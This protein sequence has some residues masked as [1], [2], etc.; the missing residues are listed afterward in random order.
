MAH[1][2]LM[3]RLCP[4]RNLLSMLW[5]KS[6][7]WNTPA[8]VLNALELFCGFFFFFLKSHNFCQESC[9]W[10]HF[11]V[12]RLLTVWCVIRINIGSG[13]VHF[14]PSRVVCFPLIAS[15]VS[16]FS[17]AVVVRGLVLHVKA[18]LSSSICYCLFW[19]FHSTFLHVRTHGII[20]YCLRWCISNWNM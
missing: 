4:S 17:R 9:F 8:S 5:M 6:S 18:A 14:S 16:L 3:R 2:K 10:P 12:H 7:F 1:L 20:Q 19:L 13:D 11:N 15:I